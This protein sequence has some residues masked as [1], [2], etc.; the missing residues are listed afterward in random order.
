MWDQDRLAMADKKLL[1]KPTPPKDG[2]RELFSRIMKDYPKFSRF[3]YLVLAALY[4]S[5]DSFQSIENM[6]V[7]NHFLMLAQDSMLAKEYQEQ[8]VYVGKVRDETVEKQEE[9]YG[10]LI[11]NR[12]RR[13]RRDHEGRRSRQFYSSC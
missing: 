13:M 2:V 8:L 3:D 1:K 4:E 5:N 7:S 9:Y 10:E 6:A 12:Q 11:L